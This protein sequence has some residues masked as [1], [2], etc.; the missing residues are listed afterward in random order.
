M[1]E[2]IDRPDSVVARARA[3]STRL[4]LASPVT[5]DWPAEVQSFSFDLDDDLAK[6][7]TIRPLP[8]GLSVEVQYGRDYV[9]GRDRYMLPLAQ[10]P[11]IQWAEFG[12]SIVVTRPLLG[13]LQ[14]Q[15]TYRF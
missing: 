6:L 10:P 11:I 15:Q 4:R 1:A 3:A 8:G 2:G 5:A 12:V 13:R 9:L 14:V 7:V